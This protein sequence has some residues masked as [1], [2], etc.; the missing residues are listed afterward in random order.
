MQPETMDVHEFLDILNNKLP[1][2]IDLLNTHAILDQDVSRLLADAKECAD[3][4]DLANL[5]FYTRS[6]VRAVFPFLEFS[7]YWFLQM[8]L[9]FDENANRLSAMDRQKVEKLVE[10]QLKMPT[11]DAL[12]FAVKSLRSAYVLSYE[13]NFMCQEWEE[14]RC[15]TSI[16]DGFMHPKREGDLIIEL[17]VY[18]TLYNGIHWMVGMVNTLVKEVVGKLSTL[19]GPSKDLKKGQDAQSYLQE[20]RSLIQLVQEGK[21]ELSA[22]QAWLRE[23]NN[24]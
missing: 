22:A 11:N 3:S 7:V 21:I 10:N 8:C 4:N 13:P 14:F 17:D 19:A 2:I 1:L 24:P 15:A 20:L 6:L 18:V 16:R 9:L 5:D 12:K 23:K